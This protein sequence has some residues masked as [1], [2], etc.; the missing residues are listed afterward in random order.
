MVQAEVADRLAA[1]PGSRTYGVPS[2]KAAWFADV[3]RAGTVGAQRVL[4]GAQRRLRPG[5]LDPP[6][7]A[8]DHGHPRAGL[9]GRRRGVRAAPQDAARRARAGWP[10]PPTPPRPPCARRAST[11]PRA[12]RCSTSRR[13][14]ASPRRCDRA[15]CRMSVTV[16]APAKINLHLG[17]GAPRDD[18]FHPLVTVYQAVGLCDD[19]T[20]ERSPGWTLGVTVP[21]WMDPDAVPVTG[22]NIVDRAARLLADHH[23]VEPRAAVSHR[24][25]DPGRRRHGR[26]APRTPPPR[27]SRSTGSGS[28]RHLRRRPARDRRR[29]GQR[30]TVRAARRH[31]PR[32]RPRRAGRAGAR[33]RDLVVGRRPVRARGSRRR[34]STGASTS[35]P[36]T[37]P[38]SP[39][40]PA[41]SCSRSRPATRGVLAA[42]LH[43]DL[44]PAALDLRPDLAE[45]LELGERSGALRGLVSGSGPTCVFLTDG[46]DDARERGR[47]A[48][49]GGHDVVLVTNGPVAGAHVVTYA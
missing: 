35:S 41:R 8:G 33:R 10:A 5:R 16:R 37:R 2:V 17:V 45:L 36:P 6:R 21:D 15:A 28:V 22:D 27:W 26:R 42:A 47:A 20:V 31:R 30:R 39:R 46:P 29:A 32:H 19:V 43:N 40:A 44:E 38:R 9:R 25:V 13:S 24:Q 23:G 48:G 12:A 11:R 49:R 34:R 18:G 1:P 3:R 7:A 14:P 4:A